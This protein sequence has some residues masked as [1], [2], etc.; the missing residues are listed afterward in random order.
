MVLNRD[1]PK[2]VNKLGH[3]V[4]RKWSVNKTVIL[5]NKTRLKRRK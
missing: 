2:S 4:N 5:E 3:M 1:D